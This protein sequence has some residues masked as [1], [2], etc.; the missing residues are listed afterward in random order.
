MNSGIYRI[1]SPSGKEYIGSAK[2]FNRR[3]AKHRHELKKSIHHC[4]PLQSAANKYGIGA[5]EFEILLVCK[6]EDLIFYE[7]LLIDAL[8]PRY[9]MC[10]KAGSALGLKRSAETCKKLSDANK[11]WVRTPEIRAA[12][13]AGRKGMKL[14]EEH[15]NAIASGN[16]GKTMSEEAKRKIGD[17]NRGRK[18]TAEQ[19]KQMSESRK[20]KKPSEEI[21]Q[22]L[23]VAQALRRE[24]ER[25]E[26]SG[27]SVS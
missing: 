23:R 24:R 17:G 2:S 22:K 12:M 21:K 16:R 15:R 26:A 9:N 19:I 6:I 8:K 18:R 14:S 27:C 3:F 11:L 1:V 4:K 25:N 20:G 10:K 13:S 5:L 7:Q